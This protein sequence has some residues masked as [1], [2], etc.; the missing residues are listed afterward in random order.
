M[1]WVGL[2]FVSRTRSRNLLSYEH[3]PCQ[4]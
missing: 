2:V 4:D 1:G 3:A